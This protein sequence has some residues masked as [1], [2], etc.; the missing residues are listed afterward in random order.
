MYNIHALPRPAMAALALLSLTACAGVTPSPAGSTPCF[1]SHQWNGW[2]SPVDDVIYIRVRTND[3]YRIDLVPGTG[4]NLESGGQFLISEV[5][6]SS[7]ICTAN[8]MELWV[9]DSV[10]IRSPLFPRSLRRLTPDEVAAL[11]PNARP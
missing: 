2:K 1:S 3:I 8:D 6:G 9:S 7:R 4:R 11:P 5:H 10:G